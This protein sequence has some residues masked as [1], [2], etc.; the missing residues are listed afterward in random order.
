MKAS[1]I[2]HLR[3]AV[4]NF[5]E[6]NVSYSLGLFGDFSGGGLCLKTI[7][8]SNPKEAVE[9]YLRWYFRHNKHRNQ[10]HTTN[11]VETSWNWGK[12]MVVDSKGYSRYFM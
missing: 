7:K 4:A 9:R 12:F 2:K 11:L 5:K 8:A 3:K 1:H 10:F 6:Y